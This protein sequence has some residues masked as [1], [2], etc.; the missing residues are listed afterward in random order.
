MESSWLPA[1]AKK[2]TA[3]ELFTRPPLDIKR[4]VRLRGWSRPMP[5][6]LSFEGPPHAPG[7]NPCSVPYRLAGYDLG[8]R[9]PLSGSSRA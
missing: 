9:S 8:R 2:K 4:A 6:H 3:Y 7:A 5:E 1:S